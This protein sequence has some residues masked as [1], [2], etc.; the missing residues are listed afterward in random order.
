MSSKAVVVDVDQSSTATAFVRFLFLFLWL[1]CLGSAVGVVYTTY[2]VRVYTQ[3]LEELRREEI[4]LRVS[5]GQFYLE[6]SSLA[7][8]PRIEAI[9]T[10]KLDMGVPLS[11]ETVLVVRE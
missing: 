9:A 7:S 2:Q 5:A 4:G 10:D 3:T 1:F 8:Y 11:N 6:R